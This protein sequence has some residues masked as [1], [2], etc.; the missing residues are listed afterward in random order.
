MNLLLRNE[1][2][3]MLLEILS[4]IGSLVFI[5]IRISIHGSLEYHFPFEFHIR[6]CDQMDS[7]KVSIQYISYVPIAAILDFNKI[8]DQSILSDH[9]HYVVASKYH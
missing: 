2:F 5:C 7:L 9:P 6:G 1:M 3:Q 4:T 8:L